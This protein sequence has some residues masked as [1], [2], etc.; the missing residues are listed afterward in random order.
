MDFDR[1]SEDLPAQR[2]RALLIG[3]GL[4]EKFDCPTDIGKSLLDRP[5]LR[6]AA[7][8]FRA[9]SV[10]SVLVL[11]DY[12]TYL[13]RRQQSS[14]HQGRL[15]A[16]FDTPPVVGGRRFFLTIIV[17]RRSVSSGQCSFERQRAEALA[18]GGVDGRAEGRRYHRDG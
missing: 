17:A 13:P 11:L 5:S 9:P 12:D 3:Q 2:R 8:Q 1:G 14:Y 10:T 6:L 4:Q 7:L 16:L 18:G 15:K